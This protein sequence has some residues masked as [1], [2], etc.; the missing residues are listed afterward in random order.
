MKPKERCSAR[1]ISL[2][3]ALVS[4]GRNRCR[5]TSSRGT[6][7][8]EEKEE[9]AKLRKEVREL[10]LEAVAK[11]CNSFA[12]CLDDLKALKLRTWTLAEELGE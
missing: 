12:S 10:R 3:S 9:L 5:W 8:S 6:L 7:T 11:K 1:C 4:P 2:T